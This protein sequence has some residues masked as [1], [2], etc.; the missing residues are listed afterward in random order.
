MTDCPIALHHIIWLILSLSFSSDLPPTPGNIWQYLKT[1][2][3][4]TGWCDGPLLSRDC[5]PISYNA[6]SSPPHRGLYNLKCHLVQKLRKLRLFPFTSHTFFF[7]PRSESYFE[8]Y[9]LVEELIDQ[10]GLSTGVRLC[11]YTAYGT[12]HWRAWV[13][14]ML[15]Q[16]DQVRTISYSTSFLCWNY[17]LGL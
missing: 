13:K 8:Y 9:V 11:L 16:N 14:D 2:F 4:V 17:L 1:Y 6:Q 12:P 15:V 10:N 5:W 7:S 3:V